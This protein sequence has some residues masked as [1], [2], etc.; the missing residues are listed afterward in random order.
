MSELSYEAS[1]EASENELLERSLSVWRGWSNICE[2]FTPIP[3]DIHTAS[4]IGQYDCVR[5]LIAKREVEIDRKNIGGWTPL[6]YACYIGHDAIVNLLIDAGCNVN[7]KNQKG[8]T[9]LMLSAS[10]GNES[11]GRFLIRKGAE[12][13]A[14]DRDGWTAL[15]HATYSG[16]QNFVSF[17]LDQRANMD[18]VE[19]STGLTPFMEAAIEGHEIIVQLFLQHGVNVNAKAYSGDT[20]RT[21]AL[22]YSYMKIVSLIDNHSMPHS[23]LRSEPGLGD[24]LSSSDEVDKRQ[25][26]Q[27][28]RGSRAKS[29]GPS[30]RDGPEAIARM[31][32]RTRTGDPVRYPHL[33]VPRGYMTFPHGEGEHA[34]TLLSYRDVTSPINQEDYHLDSSG[35]KDSCDYND[36]SNAFSK[37]GA[38][39]IKSSSSSSGGLI[40]ALG[41]SRQNSADSDDFVLHDSGVHNSSQSDDNANPNLPPSNSVA[42]REEEG[43]RG[44]KTAETEEGISG[45]LFGGGGGGVGEG[46]EGKE[47]AVTRAGGNPTTAYRDSNNGRPSEEQCDSQTGPQGPSPRQ[48][49]KETGVTFTGV[50]PDQHKEGGQPFHVQFGDLVFPGMLGTDM[51]D[52]AVEPRAALDTATSDLYSDNI[53]MDRNCRFDPADLG[54]SETVGDLPAGPMT[55][56]MGGFGGGVGSHPQRRSSCQARLSRLSVADRE[57]AAAHSKDVRHRRRSANSP[58]TFHRE[59]GGRGQDLGSGTGRVSCLSDIPTNPGPQAGYP[60]TTSTRNPSHP[61]PLEGGQVADRFHGNNP[62]PVAAVAPTCLP[63]GYPSLP[64]PSS[65]FTPPSTHAASLPPRKNSAPEISTTQ[66]SLPKS[67]TPGYQSDGPGRGHAHSR[68]LELVADLPGGGGGGGEGEGHRDL[69]AL[70]EQLGV[71]KYAALFAEQDV[72]LQVFLSLTDNDLKEIGIKLFGP[73]KKMTNAIARWHSQAPAA[74]SSLE[75]AYADRLE[76]E[77]QEMAIQLNQAYDNVEKLKAQVLQERQLRSVT[78]SCLMEERGGWQRVHHYLLDTHQRCRDIADSVNKLS[79]LHAELRQRLGQTQNTTTS[80]LVVTAAAA[81]SSDLVTLTMDQVAHLCEQYLF[82]VRQHSAALSHNMDCI[83]SHPLHPPNPSLQDGGDVPQDFP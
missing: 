33:M 25:R 68:L 8:Q 30:I 39:T 29:K 72:D 82:E 51:A 60:I 75:Q 19:P 43:D 63:P 47:S 26:P 13:E 41:L 42:T 76:G 24:Y 9:P 62:V 27:H 64:T 7:L 20:A 11:V 56:C 67:P 6:M 22:M 1:D 58:P 5:A 28:Q 73:R 17:L 66:D 10:C 15:F 40:A 3:L 16:H 37:T 81:A 12:L 2:D 55:G 71:G 54:N 14:A 53:L 32:D 59:Y 65:T 61:P 69:A 57:A 49:G 45:C 35:G 78:E 77:M 31:I 34:D 50:F 80:P 70:L 79:S 38:I 46:R 48:T 23:S 52:C 36:D 4:S 44:D 21:L 18:A 83:V 74:R